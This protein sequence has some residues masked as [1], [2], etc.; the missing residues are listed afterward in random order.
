MCKISGPNHI[1]RLLASPFREI[2]GFVSIHTNLETK[3]GEIGLNAVKPAC[4][5][6]GIGTQIYDFANIEIKKLAMRFDTVATRGDASYGR[7]VEPARN[8]GL[9]C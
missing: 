9:M 8:P 6:K 1:R 5:S 7:Q 3:V 4:S 2:V